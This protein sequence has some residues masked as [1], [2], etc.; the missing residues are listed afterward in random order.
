MGNIDKETFEQ[1]GARGCSDSDY[2]LCKTS[3]CGAWCVADDE[4]GDLHLSGDDP[5]RHAARGQ[6]WIAHT[7]HVQNNSASRSPGR[8]ARRAAAGS[9]G[10]G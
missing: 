5:T 9:G 4:L 6:S 7:E 3:C 2:D 10:S 1:R 8:R